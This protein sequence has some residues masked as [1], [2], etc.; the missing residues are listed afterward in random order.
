MYNFAKLVSAIA[1]AATSSLASATIITDVYTVPGTTTVTVQSPF[2]YMHDLTDNVAPN[3]YVVDFDSIT[4]A[5]LSIRLMD[6]GPQNGGTETFTFRLNLDGSLLYQGSNVPN[7][8]FDYSG[9]AVT[10]APLA[11]LSSTGKLS[12]TIAAQSGDFRF[13]SSTLTANVVDGV[14]TPTNVP[15]PFSIALLGVGLAGVAVSRRKA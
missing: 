12:L 14:A 2:V 13:V 3:A 7:G 8:N 1:L 15:E 11:S 5:T 4:S 6:N 9:L 10:S